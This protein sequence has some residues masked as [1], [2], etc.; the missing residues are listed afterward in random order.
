VTEIPDAEMGAS[1]PPGCGL[2]YARPHPS[3]I[4]ALCDCG[5]T[6]ILTVDPDE[7]A[8]VT[9]AREVPFECGGRHSVHWLTFTP[10]EV[11]GA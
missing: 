11:P 2:C 8:Q 10:R 4:E 9:E 3:G 5:M 1:G 7:A 6:T